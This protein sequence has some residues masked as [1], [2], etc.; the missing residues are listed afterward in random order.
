MSAPAATRWARAI[1]VGPGARR[2]LRA[3]A[4]AEGRVE[5][6]F[7]PGGYVSLGDDRVLLAPARSP[8]RT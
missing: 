2:A 4:G 1:V 3:G 6:A 8:Q 5:L 7:G